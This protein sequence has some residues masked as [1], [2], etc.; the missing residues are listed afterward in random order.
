MAFLSDIEIAQRCK[1]KPIS[2][3]ARTAHVDEDFLEHYGRYKAKV[4]LS[5]LQKSSRP[6]G[7]LV[8]VTA[9]TPTLREKAKP[10]PP[11]GWPMG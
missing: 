10:P 4:D 6:N 11:S 9:I 5:L 7:K 8:L 1:M 3:I 2:E